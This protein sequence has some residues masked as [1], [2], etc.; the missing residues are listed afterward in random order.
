MPVC[1]PFFL[2][3]TI[4]GNKRN[5][6]FEELNQ[7]S[8]LTQVS[9]RHSPLFLL[10]NRPFRVYKSVSVNELPA[11]QEMMVLHLFIFLLKSV[12]LFSWCEVPG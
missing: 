11:G 8:A 12:P 5:I 6:H 7:D 9:I 10:S 4:Q 2:D 1:L 3:T